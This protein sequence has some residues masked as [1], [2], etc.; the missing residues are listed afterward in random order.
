MVGSGFGMVHD[1]LVGGEDDETELS[2]WEDLIDEL[3]EILQF[4]VESWWDD[5]GLVESSVQIDNDLSGSLVINDLEV[6]D[7]TMFLHASKELDNNLG[8]WSEQN[9]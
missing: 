8:D 7:I 9:L 2:G 6:W 5:T 4:Q 3:L 1:T